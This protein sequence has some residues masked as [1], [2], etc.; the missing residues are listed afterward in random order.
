MKIL[1]EYYIINIYLESFFFK[2][3][4]IETKY[5]DI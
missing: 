2:F 3:E 4:I 1:F 5:T